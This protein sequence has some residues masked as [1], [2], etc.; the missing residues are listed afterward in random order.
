MCPSLENLTTRITILCNHP[1]V[2]EVWNRKSNASNI[3][4]RGIT[5]LHRAV[6]QGYDDV[7]KLLL[8]HLP[9]AD[10]MPQDARGQTPLHYSAARLYFD[11]TRT[12]LDAVG[13]SSS[14]ITQHAYEESNYYTPLHF[15]VEKLSPGPGTPEQTAIVELF[16]ERIVG[17]K[18]P[19]GAFTNYISMFFALFDYLPNFV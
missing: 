13:N 19:K 17:N 18:N 1:A 2:V 8:D 15:A 6:D 14:Y 5:P 11:V 10:K 7:V 4:D 3:V 9:E 16:L 12:L